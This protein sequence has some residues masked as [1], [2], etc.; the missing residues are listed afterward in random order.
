MS[1]DFM[2]I[3][4]NDLY[5]FTNVYLYEY[6]KYYYIYNNNYCFSISRN[7]YFYTN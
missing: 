3:I 7:F 2:I 6:N 1:M 4:I 5:H